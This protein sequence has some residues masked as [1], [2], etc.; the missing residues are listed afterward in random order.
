[1]V[2]FLSSEVQNAD[3]SEQPSGRLIINIGF[4]IE[5]LLEHAGAFIVD[6]APCHVDGFDLAWWKRFYS[7]KIAFTNL[8]VI[9]DH[10]TKRAQRQVKLS[11]FRSCLCLYVKDQ[12]AVA[13]RQF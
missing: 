13:N 3:E 12:T 6:A 9:F 4:A 10:L 8:K 2:S 5:T 1:M 11:G 7:F